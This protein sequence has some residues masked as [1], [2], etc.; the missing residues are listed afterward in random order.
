MTKSYQALH[1]TTPPVV[2][3]KVGSKGKELFRRPLHLM[4]LP[5]QPRHS[6]LRSII[7]RNTVACHS[8]LGAIDLADASVR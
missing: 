7:L 5:F 8:S 2:I 4:I 1:V 3:V 6:E